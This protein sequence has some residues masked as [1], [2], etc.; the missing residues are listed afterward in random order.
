M[1]TDTLNSTD[2]TPIYANFF[3]VLIYLFKIKNKLSNIVPI[4]IKI[5][6]SYPII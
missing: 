2:M 1:T 4:L 5:L 3:I 6:I